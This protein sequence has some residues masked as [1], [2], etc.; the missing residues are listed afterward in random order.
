MRNIIFIILGII[1]YII[2]NK[3][4]CFT[5]GFRPA[6]LVQYYSGSCTYNEENPSFSYNQSC[7]DVLLEKMKKH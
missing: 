7:R 4:E 6:H 2:I 3:H 5:I 1:I